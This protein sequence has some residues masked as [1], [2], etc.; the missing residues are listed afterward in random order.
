MHAIGRRGAL[1]GTP[2]LLAAGAPRLAAAQAW[3]PR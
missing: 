1:L 3:P 2:A